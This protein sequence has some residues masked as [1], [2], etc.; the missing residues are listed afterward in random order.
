MRKSILL[1]ALILL[2]LLGAFAGTLPHSAETEK[3]AQAPLTIHPQPVTIMNMAADG[4]TYAHTYTTIPTQVIVTHQ[5]AAELLLE[6]GLAPHIAGAVIP[7]GSPKTT[8]AAAYQQLPLLKARFVPSQ[9]EMLGLQ[10]DLIIGWAHHFLPMQLGEPGFWHSRGIATYTV[11]G[12]RWQSAPTLETDVYPTIQELGAI[13]GVSERAAAYIET[14]QHRVQAVEARVREQPAAKSVLIVQ[15]YNN[16]QFA[17]YDQHTLISHL[18]HRAGGQNLVETSPGVINAE[19]LLSFDPDYILF[20]PHN[21]TAFQELSD[22]EA[23]EQLRGIK[24]LRSLRCIRENRIIPLPFSLA[25]DGGS[26]SVD[27]LEKIVAELYP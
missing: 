17:L 7:Y 6:L 14:L 12:T 10:P 26:R 16:G 2:A 24:A 8:L 13:F 20:I 23:R 27:A 11:P 1:A 25:N 9:E 4:Q 19:Q 5:G 3:T 15:N 21:P 22:N 18:T